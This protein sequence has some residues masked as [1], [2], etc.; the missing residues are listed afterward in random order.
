MK[1]SLIGMV[2]IASMGVVQGQVKT[3][4]AMKKLEF[5]TRNWQGAAKVSTGPNQSLVLDQHEQVEYRLD[6]N[7][8]IIEG[9]G[10]RD[11]N[12]SFNAVAVITYHEPK[13]EYQ[14]QT[15]LNADEMKNTQSASDIA[16]YWREVAEGVWEW[17]FEVAQGG[18]IKYTLSLNE[19]GQW[20]EQGEYSPDGST[21]Y[22]SF[23]MVLDKKQ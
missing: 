15:W 17:G 21:W 3:Q 1:K 12:L 8:L 2:L 4:E 6:G 7:M 14:M 19:K 22:Q 9:K 18:K 13:Q 11:E 23:N 5:L 20:V 16:P 10:Y